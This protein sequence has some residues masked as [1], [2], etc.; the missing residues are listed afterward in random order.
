MNMKTNLLK[1]TCGL[2]LLGAA[3]TAPAQTD[4]NLLLN[5]NGQ[6][7]DMTDWTVVANGGSG[8]YVG[9]GYGSTL[10][11]SSYP[12]A[13][14][15]GWDVRSQTI[16]LLADG[17]TTAQLDSAP[18]ISISDWVRGYIVNGS[19]FMNVQ[20]ED[21][22]HNVIATWSN[23]SQSSPLTIT[24]SAGWIE[25]TGSLQSYGSGLRYIVFE[26]GGKDQAG[27]AGNYGAAFDAS[28]VMLVQSTPE[29]STLA[30]AGLG[31]LGL[32]WQFRRRK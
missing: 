14:S 23:G 5:A 28:S 32:L 16:D 3:A 21:A 24:S 6:T 27:W 22:S 26:D 2:A 7:G 13:T 29:P 17:F 12:F 30:L 9:T 11:G 31:G 8:W 25:A 20:L 18:T 4:T 10:P 19:Y 1:L 15:Y